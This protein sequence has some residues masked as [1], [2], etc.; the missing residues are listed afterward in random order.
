VRTGYTSSG[1]GALGAPALWRRDRDGAWQRLDEGT[2][3]GEANLAPGGEGIVTDVVATREGFVAVGSH[4]SGDVSVSSTGDGDGQ[5]H[6]GD[7]DVAV[8]TSEHGRRWE[9]A[10]SPAINDL[11]RH[12]RAFAVEAFP[13]G[14]IVVAA[15]TDQP[16]ASGATTLVGPPDQLE[17]VADSQPFVFQSLAPGQVIA[18]TSPQGT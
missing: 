14:R 7:V 5:Q 10:P 18:G 12:D 17:V 16:G 6:F 15:N 3:T 1:P 9:A 11:E 2:W 8:W 4:H 13:D